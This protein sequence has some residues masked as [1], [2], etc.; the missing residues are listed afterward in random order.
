[1][2]QMGPTDAGHPLNLVL[3]SNDEMFD[4][5]IWNKKNKVIILINNGIHP[6]EPDGI[7]ASMM[8]AKF[9][10]KKQSDSKFSS[11]ASS[12]LNFIYKNSSYYEPGHLRYPVYRV[13]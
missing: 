7:D 10:A 11:D 9:E 3:I 13:R 8:L 12:Q 4:P 5:S 6:G 1:M 2:K